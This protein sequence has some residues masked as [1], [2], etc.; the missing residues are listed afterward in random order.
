V[1]LLVLE[2]RPRQCVLVLPVHAT[3]SHSQTDAAPISRPT[4]LGNFLQ[5]SAT[6]EAIKDWLMTTLEDELIKIGAKIVSHARCVA[7]QMAEVAIHRNLFA[8][9]LRLAAELRSPPLASTA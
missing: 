4:S 7:F 9:I 1:G 8:D 5:P 2:K 3:R 6:P